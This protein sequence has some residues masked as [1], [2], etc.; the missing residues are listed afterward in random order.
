MKPDKS[1]TKQLRI[2]RGGLASALCLI[3]ICACRKAESYEKPLTPV[4]LTTVEER[5]VPVGAARYSASIQPETQVDL[6]FKIGGYVETI[7]RINEGDRLTKGMLLARLR[8][9]DL[10]ARVKG[11][12]AALAETI[13]ARNLAESQLAEAQAAHAGARTEFDRAGKLFAAESMSKPEYDAARTRVEIS[14]A[15]VDASKAQVEMMRAKA[16]AARAGI[17]EAENALSNC[18]LR[19]PSTGILLKR[20]IE[21]GSLATPGAAVLTM[22]DISSVKVVFGVPDVETPN[23]RIG[24]VLTVRS[25]AVKGVDF[26]G[27][28]TSISPSADP[29]TRIFDV[30]VTIPNPGQRLKIGMVVSLEIAGQAT[31]RPVTLV[32]LSAVIQ[33]KEKGAGYAV[34][35]ADQSGGK[36]VARLTRVSLGPPLGDMVTVNSG[37]NPGERIVVSGTTLIGD[38]EEVKV[39][40]S[41]QFPV[42]SR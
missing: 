14:A 28:L 12:R 11:A 29:K 5:A 42:S 32:P 39:V 38:G 2:I 37:I 1:K 26:R 8:D 7:A 24:S 13:A 31:A 4:T 20:D 41:S 6:A 23:L 40:S 19:A 30:E 10:T 36:T 27:R 15:R 22:A 9:T 25:E 21:V 17:E 16:D 35:K 33:M 3:S 18:E 34:F